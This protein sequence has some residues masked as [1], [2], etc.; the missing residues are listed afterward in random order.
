L[1]KAAHIIT[2]VG[3]IPEATNS[4]FNKNAEH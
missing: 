3:I 4:Q 1:H 2:V